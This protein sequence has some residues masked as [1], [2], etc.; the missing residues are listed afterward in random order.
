MKTF[1]TNLANLIKI[2]SIITLVMVGGV[3]YGFITA[4][5]EPATYAAF[6]ASIIT[7]YFTKEHN[8]A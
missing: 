8:E 5:I 3:T 6:V 4:K 7:Y 1:A 2:K